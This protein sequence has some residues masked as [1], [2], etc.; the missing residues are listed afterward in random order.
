MIDSTKTEAIKDLLTTEFPGHKV[1]SKLISGQQ[2]YQIKKARSTVAILCV[3][4]DYFADLATADEIRKNI[5]ANAVITPLKQAK[6]TVNIVLLA[7]HHVRTNHAGGARVNRK[8]G[9]L[10]DLLSNWRPAPALPKFSR[11]RFP[12][13]NLKLDVQF[14]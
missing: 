9:A 4:P 7:K 1:N 13:G 10:L 14:S 5:K 11:H 12:A 3:D 8:A 2:Y 6:D